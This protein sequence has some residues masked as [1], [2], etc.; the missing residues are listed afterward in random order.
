MDLVKVTDDTTQA[1]LEEAITNLCNHAKR[2]P[3]IIAPH[4][5][6]SKVH[7]KIDQLLVERDSRIAGKI[8]DA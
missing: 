3:R 2:L 7:G 6:W 4:S 8:L 5:A 1:D